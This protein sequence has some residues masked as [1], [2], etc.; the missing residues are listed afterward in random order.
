M[1]FGFGVV[2]AYL[3]LQFATQTFAGHERPRVLTQ[4]ANWACQLGLIAYVLNENY[5]LM[6]RRQAGPFVT[7][8]SS[9]LESVVIGV[10]CTFV[11]GL[12]V[13]RWPGLRLRP[14]LPPSS[15]T[16]RA[17]TIGV[18]T[19]L[20]HGGFWVMAS[21]F[22][23]AAEDARF[24]RLES[25]RIRAAAELS[26]LRAHLEPHFMLNTLNAIAGLV[27]EDPKKSRRLL[28]A[29]G[30]LLREAVREGQT[31][32]TVEE[33]LGWLRRYA[34]LLEARHEGALS[35]EWKMDDDARLALIP[36]LVLQPLVENAVKHGALKREGGG[37]VVIA[38]E[39]MED[40]GQAWLRCSVTDNGPGLGEPR[41]G[42][43]GLTLV[44]AQLRLRQPQGE[45][46]LESSGEGT[47]AIVEVPFELLERAEAAE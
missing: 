27:T 43:K 6:K 2:L 31:E 25:A 1:V 34:E 3:A 17:L 35:F 33:E 26:Q 36:R 29:L 18:M 46:R 30:D 37:L 41:T 8:A 32:Y 44:R 45:L 15:P 11:Y 22:P 12:V 38:A 5:A 24:N 40:S 42:S 19:G 14:G 47:R 10:A 20:M 28:A 23:F 21:I 9:M 4:L 13:E 16:T 39:R 7:L